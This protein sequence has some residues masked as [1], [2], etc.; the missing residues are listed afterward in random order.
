MKIK[1]FVLPFLI[2]LFFSCQKN[3][4]HIFYYS[5]GEIIND[6]NQLNFLNQELKTMLSEQELDQ[7]LQIYTHLSKKFNDDFQQITEKQRDTLLQSLKKILPHKA[8]VFDTLNIHHRIGNF[9]ILVFNNKNQQLE[10]IAFYQNSMRNLTEYMNQSKATQPYG[11]LMTFEKGKNLND[12]YKDEINAKLKDGRK[13]IVDYTVA[14]SFTQTSGANIIP[15]PYIFHPGS[16]WK[17]LSKRLEVNLNLND[18]KAGEFPSI[19]TNFFDLTKTISTIYSN[20]NQIQTN[21]ITKIINARGKTIYRLQKKPKKQIIQ[22]DVNNKM[23]QLF[24]QYMT[25]GKGNFHYRKKE[26]IEDGFIFRIEDVHVN[27]YIYSNDTYTIGL[28]EIRPLRINRIVDYE[29]KIILEKIPKIH[30]LIPAILKS[31]SYDRKEGENYKKWEDFNQ[32]IQEET[33]ITL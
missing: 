4:E 15:K 13:M 31:L 32:S 17:E 18:F 30:I 10:N 22:R 29:T 24:Q 5:E 14:E 8:K 23:V 33:T 11:Y 2:L 12:T 9:S 25:T 1:S 3:T 28:L 26:I 16:D 6:T 20:G 19:K 27:Q 21:T 7:S